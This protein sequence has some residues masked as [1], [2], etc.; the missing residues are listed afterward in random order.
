[1]TRVRG[2]RL[3]H[4]VRF[5]MSMT[6]GLDITFASHGEPDSAK[7][8]LLSP[9]VSCAVSVNFA[10]FSLLRIVSC[11]FDCLASFP[12]LSRAFTVP[13]RKRDPKRGIRPTNNS[14]TTFNPCCYVECPI[15]RRH[16]QH[17]PQCPQRQLG[18]LSAWITF[19]LEALL[20]Y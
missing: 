20:V 6:H 2:A 3:P 1:M 13:Q 5:A 8:V 17:I 15:S 18:G 4:L 10:S 19:S 7:L 14:N 9:F 11:C 12:L 16:P